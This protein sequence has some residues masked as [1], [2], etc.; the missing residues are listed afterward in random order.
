[1][2]VVA[3]NKEPFLQV[4]GDTPYKR[5]EDYFIKYYSSKLTVS[6]SIPSNKR[7]KVYHYLGIPSKIAMKF[8]SSS[9]DPDKPS[10]PE[11]R[12]RLLENIKLFLDS[13]AAETGN[14]RDR[15]FLAIKYGIR[16]I[17]RPMELEG[18]ARKYDVKMPEFWVP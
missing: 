8:C 6:E 5:L 9:Y 1:M 15:D 12:E 17:K 4:N 16:Q 3:A 14:T 11:M 7:A 2:T 13:Y 18:F 10:N